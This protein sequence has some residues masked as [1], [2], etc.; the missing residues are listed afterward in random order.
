MQTNGFFYS[1]HN[2]LMA[3]TM[4]TSLVMKKKSP[5]NVVIDRAYT[6]PIAILGITFPKII[7][8]T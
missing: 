7:G 2:C 5:A 4:P 1:C 3:T 8:R 6:A